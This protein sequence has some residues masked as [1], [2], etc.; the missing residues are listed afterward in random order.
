MG[1]GIGIPEIVAIVGFAVI[2][3]SVARWV[4]STPKTQ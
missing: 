4:R 3:W 1:I 2:A